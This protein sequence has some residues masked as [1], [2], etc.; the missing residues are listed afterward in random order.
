MNGKNP[1]IE[2]KDRSIVISLPVTAPTSKVRPK[3][4]RPGYQSEPLATRQCRFAD[5]DYL[6]WQISY[7]TKDESM[8]T[9]LREFSFSKPGQRENFY[10]CELICLVH[11]AKSLGLLS[12]EE[13]GNLCRVA[14]ADM[15]GGV[16]EQEEILENSDR[17]SSLSLLSEHGFEKS[18]RVMPRY[19]KRGENGKY[20][21]EIQVSPKQ[22]AVGNQAMIYLCIPVRFCTDLSGRSLIGRTA[23]EK[24]FVQYTVTD[25]NSALIVDVVTAFLLA[26]KKHREDLNH[27]LNLVA[28]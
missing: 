22:R 7:D 6:E 15:D 3:R 28:R 14:G 5:R 8:P 20:F 1:T 12:E 16:E 17:N 24:E 19:T 9:A 25:D 2:T 13:F 26:S 18:V 11:E 27:I 23:G 21:V 4:A 10:P